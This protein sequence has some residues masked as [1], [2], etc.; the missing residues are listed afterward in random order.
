ME[1]DGIDELNAEL[2]RQAR[3]APD[4]GLESV[5]IAAESLVSDAQ[6][7]APVRT[8]F[9]VDQHIVEVRRPQK[10]VLIGANTTYAA[11]VHANHP[12]KAGW[13]LNT[14][15]ANGMSAVRAAGEIVFRRRE[16]QS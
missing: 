10:D 3:R 1:L 12:T 14:I 6:T 13:L 4:M 16:A 15:L 9:L 7:E 2:R 11:A 5:E 8:G